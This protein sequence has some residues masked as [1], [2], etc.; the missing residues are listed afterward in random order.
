MDTIVEFSQ[1]IALHSAYIGAD[2]RT[3]FDSNI[4]RYCNW[5]SNCERSDVCRVCHHISGIS[6]IIEFC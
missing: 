2:V 5:Q 6:G 1:P 4:A 3:Q